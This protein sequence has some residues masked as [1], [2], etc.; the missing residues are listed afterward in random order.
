MRQMPVH[1]VSGAR[2]RPNF[3]VFSRSITFCTRLLTEW[4]TEPESEDRTSNGF[5]A[6]LCNAYMT[7]VSV[8]PDTLSEQEIEKVNLHSLPDDQVTVLDILSYFYI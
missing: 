4:F 1:H 7:L 6:A 8:K 3:A 5:P 2:N